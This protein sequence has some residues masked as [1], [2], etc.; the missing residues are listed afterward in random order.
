MTQKAFSYFIKKKKS[1]GLIFQICYVVLEV[2]LFTDFSTP[3]TNHFISCRIVLLP[4]V[5]ARKQKTQ[6]NLCIF[7]GNFTPAKKCSKLN[8]GW[9]SASSEPAASK[10]ALG[11][12]ISTSLSVKRYFTQF[13]IFW[14]IM[15]NLRAAVCKAEKVSLL[16]QTLNKMY[17][18]I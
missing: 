9:P 13:S 8:R 18:F 17:L 15:K 4:C 10:G 2:I 12:E 5:H 1:Q 16:S 6:R 14:K 7:R 11:A 3:L